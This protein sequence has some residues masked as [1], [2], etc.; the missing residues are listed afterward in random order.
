MGLQ[1]ELLASSL[2]ENQE[3]RE[4]LTSLTILRLESEPSSKAVACRRAEAVAVDLASNGQWK[5]A[6]RIALE[7]S[8]VL[9]PLDAGAIAVKALDTAEGMRQEML[10]DEL[11]HETG[12]SD[13]GFH[14]S[15]ENWNAAL[16]RMLRKQQQGPGA[17]AAKL[18]AAEALTVRMRPRAAAD[19]G[20]A[21]PSA[22]AAA[23]GCAARCEAWLAC[24][25]LGKAY[26]EAQAC[27]EPRAGELMRDVL[28]A[29]RLEGDEA[30]AASAQHFLE[31]KHG[32]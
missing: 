4:V 14:V 2:D 1:R 16:L 6:K 32:I 24:S 23:V 10:L 13:G 20:P 15:N 19:G 22:A 8:P 9:G 18:A 29:A 26:G 25:Q 17:G 3:E 5:F 28:A 12:T 7:L 11:E 30:T 27:A 21:E 31:S